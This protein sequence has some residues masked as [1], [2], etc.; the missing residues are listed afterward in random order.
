M[1]LSYTYYYSIQNIYNIY[2][3]QDG[4]LLDQGLAP[5]HSVPD[6][7]DDISTV[8]RTDEH[9]PSSSPTHTARPAQ[10]VDKVD[11]RVGDIEQDD[12]ADGD[13]I[14]TTWSEICRNDDLSI[15]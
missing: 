8:S 3:V 14:Y 1:Q 12:M 13:G 11:R 5:E 10:S 7:L 6:L 9:D 4:T 15:G 2:I